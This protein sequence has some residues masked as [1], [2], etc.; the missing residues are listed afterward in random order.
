MTKLFMMFFGCRPIRKNKNIAVALL[1]FFSI[2]FLSRCISKSEST[3]PD[4]R[5]AE[6]A[7]SIACKNCHQD[8][9]KAYIQTAHY[10]T[11]SDSLSSFVKSGFQNGKNV[12][13]FND[14]VKV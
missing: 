5:G 10:N 4:I 11:S 1:I 7:G 2:I 14:S 8:I 6:F 12:F 3:I 9:Y 13:E